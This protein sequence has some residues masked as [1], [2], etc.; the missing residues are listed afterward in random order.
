MHGGFH[1]RR[2]RRPGGLPGRY[3]DLRLHSD[4]PHG[5]GDHL[6]PRLQRQRLACEWAGGRGARR[7][8]SG[9]DLLR[10]P[11]G[12]RLGVRHPDGHRHGPERFHGHRRP[13]GHLLRGDAGLCRQPLGFDPHLL[14]AERSHHLHL[15]RNP[16]QRH[17]HRRG[18]PLR[19]AGP[20]IRP[21]RLLRSA[22]HPRHH[23]RHPDRGRSR[24]SPQRPRLDGP[25]AGAGR[26]RL[27]IF[28][29]RQPRRFGPLHDR[30]RHRGGHAP[31]THRRHGLPGGHRHESLRRAVRTRYLHDE[32]RSDLGPVPIL[33]DDHPPDRPRRPDHDPDR[34]D[35]LLRPGPAQPVRAGD[36]VRR[37]HRHPLPGGLRGPGWDAGAAAHRG[38]DHRGHR[39]RG[40]VPGLGPGGLPSLSGVRPAPVRSPVGPGGHHGGGPGRL[41]RHR[42]GD[43]LAG[44]SLG[45]GGLWIRHPD[46]RCPP[47]RHCHRLRPRL[48]DNDP[49]RC[50]RRQ[51]HRV[52][53]H[54]PIQQ[55]LR[56]IR[57][58]AQRGCRRPGGDRPRRGRQQYRR[59]PRRVRRYRRPNHLARRSQRLERQRRRDPDLRCPPRRHAHCRRPRLRHH[60][61]HR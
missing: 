20:A 24:R 58:R 28:H 40:R 34:P 8:R 18:F 45:L 13:D 29:L 43:R 25:H 27:R 46:L 22:G 57:R 10:D 51:R 12:R 53:L 2:S 30:S 15:H 3:Q 56:A 47:G 35:R 38:P 37:R 36:G 42:R 32:Q 5:G 21:G 49:Y 48:W 23:R 16:S 33:R 60:H 31:R 44:R 17:I 39:R 7:R 54:G 4:Q 14:R 55:R 41:R 61:L 52:H 9:L 6:R 11:H 19:P 1:F 59:R 50:H 26:H